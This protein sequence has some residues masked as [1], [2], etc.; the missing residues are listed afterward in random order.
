MGSR[1]RSLLSWKR[2]SQG[3]VSESSGSQTPHSIRQADSLESNQLGHA[4]STLSN[5]TFN[6]SAST[7]FQ[8]SA[9]VLA[10]QADKACSIAQAETTLEEAGW[11]DEAIG[12]VRNELLTQ[13]PED[14]TILL[15]GSKPRIVSALRAFTKGLC[16]TDSLQ[17]SLTIS[18]FIHQQPDTRRSVRLSE[19][20]SLAWAQLQHNC[21]L[22]IRVIWKMLPPH[23]K[24]V[25]PFAWGPPPAQDQLDAC[26]VY[27]RKV[28][29]SP[30]HVTWIDASQHPTL[31]TVDATGV[32]PFGTNTTTDLAICRRSAARPHAFRDNLLVL[33]EVCKAVTTTEYYQAYAHLLLANVHSPKQR[34]VAVVTD[35]M[36]DWSIHWLDRRRICTFAAPDRATAL[37]VIDC[38]I[39]DP[40]GHR[41]DKYLAQDLPILK[42]RALELGQAGV[43]NEERPDDDVCGL[44]PPT[45]LVVM[46]EHKVLQELNN[47]PWVASLQLV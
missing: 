37:A 43:I 38:L 27:L 32:L 17:D 20:R 40:R 33:F 7:S 3:P 15:S 23:F 11:D 22:E 1:S 6:S 19:V 46:K 45:E 41:A 29:D 25:D 16:R 36:D 9:S 31:L 39:A 12:R 5:T 47:I 18:E 28:I 8:P 24:Q 35:L 42:R 2:G 21:R 10:L 4:Q 13:S 14:L 34:P 44:L 30:R 26:S